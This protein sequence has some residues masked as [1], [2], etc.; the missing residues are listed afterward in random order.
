MGIDERIQSYRNKLKFASY[1]DPYLKAIR[2]LE[3]EKA[4]DIY[5][6][7]LKKY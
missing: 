3:K 2:V 7:K 6:S 1:P 4:K 5:R